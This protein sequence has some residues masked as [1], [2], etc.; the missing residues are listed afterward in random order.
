LRAL[1]G[2]L[3]RRYG[4]GMAAEAML[5]IPV[6]LYW[7]VALT[8]HMNIGH[9]HLLPI[10]PFLI[11]F[12]SKIGRVFDSLRPRLLVVIG[13]LL[14]GWNIWESAFIY[15][16]YLAYFNQIA[17]G[18][19]GGYRWL[20]DSNL[21]WGQDLKGLAKYMRAHPDEPFYFSYFGTGKPQYYGIQGHFLPCVPMKLDREYVGFDEVP[22]G[23]LVAVSATNLQC[24][25]NDAPGIEPFMKR[26]RSLKPIA[27]IGYSIKI[28][29]NP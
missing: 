4:A 24:V 2:I 9:R 7:G 22:S 18:P 13:V 10:Y 1:G 12:A 15:P 6:V 28:Y 27:E 29:R 25:Y 20:V 8:S 16:H 5:L 11:V 26:L 23:A 14:I 3:I 17:G 21:D 19:S